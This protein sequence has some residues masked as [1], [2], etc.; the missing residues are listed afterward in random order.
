MEGGSTT[1]PSLTDSPSLSLISGL[2]FLF[3]PVPL[4][5]FHLVALGNVV[6]V[7]PLRDFVFTGEGCMGDD[8]VSLGPG[9]DFN[10]LRIEPGLDCTEIVGPR[11]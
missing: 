8:K 10:G 11:D 7:L 4:P 2:G 6:F 9:R 3:D 1:L 5:V